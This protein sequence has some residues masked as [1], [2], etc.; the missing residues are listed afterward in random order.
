MTASQPLLCTSVRKIMILKQQSRYERIRRHPDGHNKF[1]DQFY[2]KKKRRGVRYICANPVVPLIV[3]SAQCI[4]HSFVVFASPYWT[5]D[6]TDPL[7]SLLSEC[8]ALISAHY[9]VK[10]SLRNSHGVP[11]NHCISMTCA[12]ISEYKVHVHIQHGDC[13]NANP[14]TNGTCKGGG[15]GRRQGMALK[16]F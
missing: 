1:S 11:W 7:L 16:S 4:T 8:R 13:C 9:P 3:A 2:R 14:A 6:K 12:P 10:C 5:Q 15:G